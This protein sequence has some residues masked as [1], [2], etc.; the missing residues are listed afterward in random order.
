MWHTV[1]LKS[2]TG[3]YFNAPILIFMANYQLPLKFQLASK[4]LLVKSTVAI[5]SYGRTLYSAVWAVIFDERRRLREN[6]SY[7]QKK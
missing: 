6:F 2:V 5:R 3:R 7:K 4:L 1:W